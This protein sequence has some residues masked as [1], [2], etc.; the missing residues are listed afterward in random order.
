[1]MTAFAVGEAPRRKE[2]AHC[3]RIGTGNCWTSAAGREVGQ[4][5]R[6]EASR[7]PPPTARQLHAISSATGSLAAKGVA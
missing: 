6:R 3:A 2:A 1:M 5:N 4:V 7:E